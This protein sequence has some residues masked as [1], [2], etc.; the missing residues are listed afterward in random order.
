M[1]EVV[2]IT[3]KMSISRNVGVDGLSEKEKYE[4]LSNMALLMQKRL[5]KDSAIGLFDIEIDEVKA[6]DIQ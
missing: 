4:V 1:S 3:I 6:D 2:K 5:Q